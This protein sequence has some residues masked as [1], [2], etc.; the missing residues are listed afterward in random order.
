MYTSD[1]DLNVI[2]EL[3]ELT[4]STRYQNGWRLIGSHMYNANGEN[5]Y[6]LIYEQPIS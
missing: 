4:L 2:E 1:I 6:T 5:I 3:L